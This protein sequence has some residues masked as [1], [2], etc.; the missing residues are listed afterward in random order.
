MGNSLEDE[1]KVWVVGDMRS[2]GA[3][4]DSMQ[5]GNKVQVIAAQCIAIDIP[6][7][8]GESIIKSNR[9]VTFTTVT[10]HG[11]INYLLFSKERLAFDHIRWVLCKITRVRVF[12]R[13]TLPGCY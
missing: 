3:M 13:E 8:K 10:I 5:L 7:L 12:G 4:V 9:I 2:G 6:H 1:E 11:I